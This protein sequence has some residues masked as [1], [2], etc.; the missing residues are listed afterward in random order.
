MVS[1]P[2]TILRF[3][4][5]GSQDNPGAW[6]VNANRFIDVVEEAV[7]GFYDV[8]T[9]GGDTTLTGTNYASDQARRA[10]IRIAN[11]QTLASLVRVYSTTLREYLV[12]NASAAGSFDVKFGYDSSNLVTI[13]RGCACRVLVRSGG[14][15]IQTSALIDVATGQVNSASLTTL[16]G[17]FP[18]E[19]EQSSFGVLSSTLATPP[20]APTTGDKYI[21]PVGGLVGWTGQDAKIA[22]WDGASW[23]YTNPAAG[24]IA[25][26]RA[27]HY[28]VGYD[29]GGWQRGAVTDPIP[30]GGVTVMPFFQAA[31]PTGWTKKTTHHNKGIRIT[32]GVDGGTDGGTR[33]FSDVFGITAVDGHALSIS[34]TALH[35]HGASTGNQNNSHTHGFT[36]VIS[37]QNIASTLVE[38][39]TAKQA[40]TPTGGASGASASTSGTESANHAHAI[41]GQ[42]GGVAHAHNIDLRLAYLNMLLASRD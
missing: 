9:T 1:T 39:G 26:D 7:A 29:A 13:P 37:A 10:Y 41:T 38:N 18:V 32:T 4:K 23:A 31:A 27:N 25:W 36:A 17:R 20:G 24:M 22:E 19:P 28:L 2:T 33:G 30:A 14:T 16:Y 35:D 42:G 40:F 11:G 3:E 5:Q 8:S 15:V 21:V 6:D 34:E 12:H